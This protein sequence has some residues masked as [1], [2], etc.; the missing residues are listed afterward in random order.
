MRTYQLCYTGMTP[1][2]FAMEMALACVQDIQKTVTVID[3]VSGASANLRFTPKSLRRDPLE[4]FFTLEE[5]GMES[6][7]GEMRVPND[8][9][10]SINIVV[11]D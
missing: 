1:E 2:A 7:K 3:T 6:S 10:K 5:V 11:H 4:W 8:P 9:A